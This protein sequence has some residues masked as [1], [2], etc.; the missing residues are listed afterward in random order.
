M[1]KVKLSSITEVYTG[2]PFKGQRYSDHGIRT[3]RG[4][5]VT[6]GKLRW[7][8]TKCWNESFEDSENYLL[9]EDD[10]VIGMDGSKVGKNKARIRSNDLPLLLAQRVACIRAKKGNDQVFIYYLINN[11]LFEKYVFLTQ[12]GSSVPHI[13]KKQIEDYLVPSFD[14]PSQQKIAA[15]LSALDDKID[16]NNQLND[17]LPNV[18]STFT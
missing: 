12:T 11:P 14:L 1:N 5:N 15:V 16:L 3:V 7:D 13:S 6:E 10:V 9:Y 17:N 8:T 2:F 18:Y 4:E